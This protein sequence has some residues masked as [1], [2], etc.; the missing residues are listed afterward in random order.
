MEP[1]GVDSEAGRINAKYRGFYAQPSPD[2]AI[3][4]LAALQHA[5]F[6]LDQLVEA[7][8]SKR[9]VQS[10]VDSGRLHR[11]HQAV[12]SLVPAALLTREGHWLAAVLACGPEAALSHESAAAL[13]GLRRYSGA[14]IEVVVPGQAHRN[15]PHLN[16]HRSKTL[17]PADITIVDAIPCTIVAR[18]LLDL[19]ECLNRRNL[20]RAFDQA[21][22]SGVFDLL[23]I[24]DQLRRNPT[25]KAAKLIR[26]LLETHYIGRTPTWTELEEAFLALI[27]RLGLPDP[28]VNAW[29]VLGDGLRAIRV[30]FVWRDLRVIVET[31][32]HASHRTR[33]Q[34][35][36]DRVRDQR[37]TVAG[38]TVIRT[39]WRQIMSRP[40]ELEPTLR[41]LVGA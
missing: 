35:E 15:R 14:L 33:Q 3:S 12:Y 11:I 26:Q 39:T 6:H 20:E 7:G 30:D 21:E 18:T 36:L 13:H 38:Y 1:G 28:E 24:Q 9:A 29:I 17:T 10:R 25:R 32:G 22:V 37:L 2:A 8:L 40:H 5:V 31:D 19:A 41:A 23:A 4:A 34:F 16:V 27:R